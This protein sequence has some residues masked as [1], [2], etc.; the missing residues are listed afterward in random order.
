MIVEQRTY[1]LHPGKT[2][3]YLEL[4]E[5]EGLHIQQPILGTMVGYFSTEFGPLNRIV[6]MWAYESFE[7]REERRAKLKANPD[8]KEFAKKLRLLIRQQENA[9]L[10][11]APFSPTY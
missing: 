2:A 10:L 7:D 1:T 4:Y 9:I 3:E 8:W 6:H 5:R 11:P